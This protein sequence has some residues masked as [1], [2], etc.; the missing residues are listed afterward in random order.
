MDLLSWKKGRQSGGVLWTNVVN[1]ANL[2]TTAIS[3]TLID[4]LRP[5]LTELSV[6]KEEINRFSVFFANGF[7]SRGIDRF[8]RFCQFVFCQQSGVGN[9]QNMAAPLI[10]KV[11]CANYHPFPIIH[12]LSA[13]HLAL[14]Y[15]NKLK[16]S[17]T[18]WLSR[19]HVLQQYISVLPATRPLYHRSHK[20]R[21]K[22]GTDGVKITFLL[23]FP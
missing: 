14:L 1:E 5:P 2:P 13:L 4:Y 7:V 10:S 23:L 11:D 22:K 18:K 12:H 19:Y 16:F 20:G 8:A 21:R 9:L 15:V 6:V 17:E 3:L